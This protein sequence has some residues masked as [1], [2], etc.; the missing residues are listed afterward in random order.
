MRGVLCLCVC[1]GV[2]VAD[3]VYHLPWLLARATFEQQSFPQKLL[4]A[5]TSA[6][7]L[8][9]AIASGDQQGK[10]AATAYAQAI[11]KVWEGKGREGIGG[12]GKRHGGQCDLTKEDVFMLVVCTCT[13]VYIPVRVHDELTINNHVTPFRLW[14]TGTFVPQQVPSLQQKQPILSLSRKPLQLHL[15]RPLRLHWEKATPRCACFLTVVGLLQDAVVGHVGTHNHSPSTGSSSRHCCSVQQ[16]W[17][18]CSLCCQG[19]RKAKGTA[20]GGLKPFHHHINTSR[21]FLLQAL[22][23]YA[24]K[25]CGAVARAFAEATVIADNAGWSRAYAL[26]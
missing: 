17:Y 6:A 19:R 14:V 26:V 25:D 12:C 8:A 16:R 9:T 18:L 21:A 5:E 11:S 24:Q 15:H 3:V 1:G 4:Q 10:A 13:C 2:G 23:E 20:C 7:A 22:A